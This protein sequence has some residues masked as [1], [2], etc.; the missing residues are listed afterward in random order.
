MFLSNLFI[1]SV[2]GLEFYHYKSFWKASTG[3]R[4]R[5]QVTENINI[6]SYSTVLMFIPLFS[7]YKVHKYNEVK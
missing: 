6:F 1:E 3:R 2:R 5:P 7:L 4:E